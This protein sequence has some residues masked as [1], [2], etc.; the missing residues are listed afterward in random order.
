MKR[1]M[2]L[3]ALLALGVLTLAPVQAF[4][5]DATQEAVLQELRALKNRVSELEKD[6]AEAK[7]SANDARQ[8]ASEAR[9]TSGQSLKMSQEVAKTKAK[10]PE[11]LLTE[12]GKRLKIYGAVEL[13]G[14]WSDNK[15]DKGES[16]TESDLNL[17]TAEVFFDA[18]INDYTKGLVHLLWEQGGVGFH[19]GRRGLHPGGPDRG[20]AFLLPGRPHVSGHRHV[21]DLH[22][23]RSHHSKRL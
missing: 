12:A 13:E 17:A 9:K 23:E 3:G 21:R 18:T 15:P 11:G 4:G 6:L 14:S 10:Q 5:A 1:I 2:R 16:S 19:R 22:G 8:A 7:Q 20:H